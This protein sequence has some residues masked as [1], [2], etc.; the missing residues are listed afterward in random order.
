M[1]TEFQILAAY[2]EHA[3]EIVEYDRS[4][5]GQSVEQK[6]MEHVQNCVRLHGRL[7]HFK[8]ELN[9]SYGFIILLEIMFSTVYF[10]LTAFNMIF[11]GNTFVMMKG[12]LTLSNYMAEFFIFCM[13]GSMV[14]DAHIKL[15]RATYM[16]PWY[17]QPV[18]YRR[19]LAMIAY[20]S[21]RP[22]KLTVGKVF[23]VN[24]SLFLKMI[25]VSYSGVNALRAAN[26]S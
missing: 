25:K 20:R 5:S 22:L 26:A 7:I 14:E 16:S 1:I 2:V 4:D 13:Y 24:L 6:L 19:A 17:Q 12:L 3:T 8:D 11:I 9:K 23:T 18:P 21:Q 15:L 10:C